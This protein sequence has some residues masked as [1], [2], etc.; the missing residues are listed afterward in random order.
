ML[1]VGIYGPNVGQVEFWETVKTKLVEVQDRDIIV[2][3]DFNAAI[4]KEIVQS[5]QRH[6][7][8]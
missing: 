3:G 8:F 4:N 7:K 1:I 2:L 5:L 6:Q